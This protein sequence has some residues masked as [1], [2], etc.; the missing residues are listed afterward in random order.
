MT[1][2]NNAAQSAMQETVLTDL[3]I[4]ETLGTLFVALHPYGR[5][6]VL[7]QWEWEKAAARAIESAVLSKLCAPVASAEVM[8]ALNWV[9]DFIARCN[10]DD[11]G[12]CDSVNVLRRALTSAPVAR[13]QSVTSILLEV[14]PGDDAMRHEVYA[15]S[16]ED[17]KRHINVLAEELEEWELGIRR[18]PA[19]A[20]VAGE[21]VAYRVLRKDTIDGQWKADGRGWCDGEPSRDL[22]DALAK[23]SDN[24]RIERAYAA[25]QASEAQCSCPSGDGSL[26]HPCAVHPADVTLPSL[27]PITHEWASLIPDS[28]A[29]ALKNWACEYTRAAI[30][31]DRQ[32]RAALAAPPTKI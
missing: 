7:S 5:R 30:L 19:S 10:R 13:E 25:P 9:D 15:T 27:P 22:V 4:Q 6:D 32:Q 20:P 23:C 21:A 12:S 17:V 28:M 18:L 8:D 31:A 24:W 11:R 16:V 29:D 26:R 14:V 2:Q 1:N 3:E